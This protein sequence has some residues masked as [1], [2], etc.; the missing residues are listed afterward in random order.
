MNIVMP[1][2]EITGLDQV[3]FEEILEID[4]SC[5]MKFFQLSY[6]ISAMLIL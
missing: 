2:L 5:R 4:L 6:K 3:L 1:G